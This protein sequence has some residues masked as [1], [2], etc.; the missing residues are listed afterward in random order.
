MEMLKHNG[1]TYFYKY[2]KLTAVF[3]WLI[4][5]T[6]VWENTFIISSILG[7]FSDGI[8]ISQFTFE[9]LQGTKV[10]WQILKAG[11]MKDRMGLIGV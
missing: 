9:M 11:Y 8:E 1:S 2:I 10:Y 7:T 3:S 4:N 5:G 6:L